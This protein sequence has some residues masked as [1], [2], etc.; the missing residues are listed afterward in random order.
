MNTQN[1]LDLFDN[2]IFDG[3]L[4]EDNFW[5]KIVDQLPNTCCCKFEHGASKMVII[6]EGADY[7]IKIPFT[8][9]EESVYDGYDEDGYD[10]YHQEYIDFDNSIYGDGWD[11]CLTEAVHYN[12]AKR[13]NV[14]KIFCKTRCIGKVSGHPIY[15]QERAETYYSYKN[16]N[17]QSRSRKSKTPKE[18]ENI[19]VKKRFS[20]FNIRWQT[21]VYNYYG[22]K[23]FN[24][25]MDF[26][27]KERIQDLHSDNIGYL[28]ARPVILDYSGWFE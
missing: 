26:I 18:V 19:C 23:I 8:G 6:P 27:K 4:T 22:E 15:I 10:E 24:K 11:Y 12:K 20:Q 25:F 3:E 14:E 5:Y 28:G 7:V 2:C 17:M 1:I 21:D 13:N 16:K 9:Q